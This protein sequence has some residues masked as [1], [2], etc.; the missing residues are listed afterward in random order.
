MEQNILMAQEAI[1]ERAALPWLWWLGPI[2]AI[3]ALGYAYYF[4]RQVMKESEGT[5]KM[6]EIAQA[7]RDGAMAY[8][9]RQYRVV[10]IV[11]VVL[12]FFAAISF[13]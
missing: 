2:A 1:A 12:F 5:P 3:L 9:T 10:T 6:I 7:V 11:F 4:Y 8:L 13:S